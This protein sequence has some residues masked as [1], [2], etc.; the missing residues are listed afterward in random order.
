MVRILD[1]GTLVVLYTTTAQA[2]TTY[3][4]KSK[5]DP[6]ILFMFI[7]QIVVM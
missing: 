5:K 4:N 1:L 6:D 2:R 3:N 7:Q